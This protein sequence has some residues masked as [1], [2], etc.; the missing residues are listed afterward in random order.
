VR[1]LV[2]LVAV[3]SAAFAA[4]VAL[5]THAP[6]SGSGTSYTVL[7]MNLCLSGMAGCYPRTSYPAILDEAAAQVVDHEP[8][9]VTLNEACSGDAR[10]MATRTGYHLRFAAVRNGAS[11]LPCVKPGGRGVFGIAVLTKAPIVSSRDRAFRVQAGFEQR[12][13]VCASTTDDV[14][15]C[16]AHLST[17]STSRESST[18]DAECR[19]L[20]GV[21][22][23]YDATGTT[24]FGGDVNR[25][26]PCAPPT[27]WATE[28]GAAAQ[29][30][31]IQHV[32]GSATLD[33]PSAR[34]T[35]AV[36]TDHDFLL[37]A[38]RLHARPRGDR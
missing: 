6:A 3:A 35:A 12:R 33:A 13:W 31:G 36:H 23:G 34:V 38:G 28:D 20:R 8:Q 15:A 18:N 17:R 32:Y 9:V 26:A 11:T 22:A 29:L 14:T 10:T 1:K 21:L 16:T 5:P 25:Q 19:E 2:P 37:T 7:Q 24:V 30:S 4:V 27:M